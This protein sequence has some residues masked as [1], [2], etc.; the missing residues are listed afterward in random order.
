MKVPAGMWLTNVQ[1]GM[2]C[3]A[4][5]VQHGVAKMAYLLIVVCFLLI[6]LLFH[7]TIHQALSHCFHIHNY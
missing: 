5:V 3:V 1:L 6:C 4:W 2:A 7:V